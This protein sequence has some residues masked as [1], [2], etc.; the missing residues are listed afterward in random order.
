MAKMKPEID[1][2]NERYKEDPQQK[3]VAMRKLYDKHGTSMTAPLKGCAPMM[4]QLPIFI[5][6]YRIFA[7][8]IVLRGATFLWITDLAAPD[9]LAENVI[10]GL[11]LNLLPLIMLVTQVATMLVS[12][13]ITDPNQKI[14]FIVMPFMMLIFFYSMPS[15]LVLYWI[16]QNV[17]QMGHTILTNREVEHEEHD[18][19][20]AAVTVGG[21]GASGGGG[22]RRPPTTILD[23]EGSSSDA[24]TAAATTAA[25]PRAGGRDGGGRLDGPLKSNASER[26][27]SGKKR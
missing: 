15:G 27:R 18:A 9:R 7:D 19:E 16:M 17:W 4:L 22:A 3:Y 26:R 25:A 23:V 12:S 10:G 8:Y 14:M 1:Q 24:A 21:H 6:L 13:K 11:D 5:A 20:L 2:I